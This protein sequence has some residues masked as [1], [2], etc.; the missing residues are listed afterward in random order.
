MQNPSALLVPLRE[1]CA[2]KLLEAL[3]EH[4]GRRLRIHSHPAWQTSLVTS[5]RSHLHALSDT[6]GDARVI[7]GSAR[8]FQPPPASLQLSLWEANIS[9]RARGL[10][11]VSKAHRRGTELRSQQAASPLLALMPAV[12]CLSAMQRAR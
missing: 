6:S 1:G 7:L 4:R 11:D 8:C 9:T 10:Q 5:L 12:S 3:Q 2:F